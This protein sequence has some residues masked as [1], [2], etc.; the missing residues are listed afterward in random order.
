MTRPG[1]IRWGVRIVVLAALAAGAALA[2]ADGRWPAIED[3]RAVRADVARSV[4]TTCAAILL[5]GMLL[6]RR[7]AFAALVLAP[8]LF[9]VACAT[10]GLALLAPKIS[11]V[12]IAC[13]APLIGISA[14]YGMHV[15]YRLESGQTLPDAPAADAW[16]LLFPLSRSSLTTVGVLLCLLALSPPGNRWA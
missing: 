13:A 7:R 2:C 8:A 12:T 16:G 6:F 14:G 9:G 11:V 15:L 4:L 1:A 3:A 5:A 10:I